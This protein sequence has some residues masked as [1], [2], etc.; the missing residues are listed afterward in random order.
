MS[1]WALTSVV[2]QVTALLHV[3]DS[4]PPR[5]TTNVDMAHEMSRGRNNSV[6]DFSRFG[7]SA[8]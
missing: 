5:L 7:L 3:L 4:R 8:N 2:V 1:Y 6:A